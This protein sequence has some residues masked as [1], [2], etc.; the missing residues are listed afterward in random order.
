MTVRVVPMT[1][2]H[3]EAASEV[4]L[5]AFRGYMNGRLGRRYARALLTWFMTAERGIT[6]VALGDADR[7][8]G[9]VAGAPLGYDKPLTRAL[10][11]AAAV[12]AALRPWLLFDADIRARVMTRLRSLA[13]RRAESRPSPAPDTMS[14]VAIGVASPA[15]GQHVGAALVGAFEQHAS[16]LGMQAVR[17]SVYEHN[18]AARR[19]YERAGWSVVKTEGRAI[20][21]GRRL[22]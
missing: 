22:A 8:V 17:L 21:F 4:H 12:S 13:S 10:L 6:L 11:P 16:A 3:L 19:L 18:H 2:A 7:V 14:L 5:D 1:A 9:Y 20:Y 15:R